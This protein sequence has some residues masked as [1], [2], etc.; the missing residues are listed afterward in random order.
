MLVCLVYLFSD[1]CAGVSVHAGCRTLALKDYPCISSS[2]VGNRIHSH[3]LR[4][5]ASA[6]DWEILHQKMVDGAL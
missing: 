3:A 5:P 4:F 1:G 6:E 2:S